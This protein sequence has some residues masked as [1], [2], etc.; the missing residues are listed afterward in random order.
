MLLPDV[1]AGQY[2]R[3]VPRLG[4]RLSQLAGKVPAGR[5]GNELRK[6]QLNT[7]T[8]VKWWCLPKITQPG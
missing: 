4:A 3:W 6:D 5:D 1:D 7:L 2:L 8:P